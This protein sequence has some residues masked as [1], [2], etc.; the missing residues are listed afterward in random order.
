MS[1]W[2]LMAE[3][4]QVATPMASVKPVKVTALPVVFNVS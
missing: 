2:N 3:N 1:A 4:I